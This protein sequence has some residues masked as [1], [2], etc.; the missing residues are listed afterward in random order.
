[1]SLNNESTY[2]VPLEVKHGTQEIN[3][4]IHKVIAY[5]DPDTNDQIVLLTPPRR[6]TSAYR[7]GTLTGITMQ[8]VA[9]QRSISVY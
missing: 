9:V 5:T 7:N 1:M 2:S 6:E 3:G 4:K 8:M